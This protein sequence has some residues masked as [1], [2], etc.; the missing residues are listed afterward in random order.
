MEGNS[1]DA[2]S[3][4]NGTDNVITYGSSYGKIMQ[5]ALL[6]GT[7]SWIKLPN[8]ARTGNSLTMSIWVKPTVL[9]GVV[10]SEGENAYANISLNS[11]GS[12]NLENKTSTHAYQLYKSIA[13]GLVNTGSW[14]HLVYV[15][16][17]SSGYL[18]GY[19]NGVS[20]ISQSIGGNQSY[21]VADNYFM[22][23]CY[24]YNPSSYSSF[25]SGDIDEVGTWSRAL[26][27]FEVGE[28][29]NGGLGNGY[30]LKTQSNFLAFM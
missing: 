22:L 18:T 15:Y 13:T 1:N 7:S 27:A 16:D 26:S 9:G 3:S 4:N 8:A 11:D 28:L 23:G 17:S 12:I 30:P 29:Y 24:G 21:T 19:V 10:I 6:N 25:F 5:G 20:V 14:Y 2:V